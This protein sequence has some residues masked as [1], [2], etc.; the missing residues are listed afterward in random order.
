[1]KI[2]LLTLLLFVSA[3][4]LA[5]TASQ[6]TAPQGAT[7]DNKV[8]SDAKVAC[9]MM[10]GKDAKS[11]CHHDSAAKDGKGKMSCCDGK[12]GMSCMKAGD[13]SAD[14][15]G[16]C[17]SGADMKACREKC[18]KASGETAMACCGNGGHCGM[19]HEHA[20]LGK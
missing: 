20:D 5:Q 11:C 10:A 17:C 19:Q 13:K 12:D 2:R 6:S 16:K 14:G 3:L 18:E 8:Q 9:P 1:M 15:C 7:P 4:C